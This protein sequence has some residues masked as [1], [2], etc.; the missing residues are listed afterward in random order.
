VEHD[1]GDPGAALIALAKFSELI[2]DESWRQRFA[3]APQQVADDA[4]IDMSA[5]PKALTDMSG[6][7]LTVVADVCKELTAEGLYLSLPGGGTLCYL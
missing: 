7:E 6:D 1:E 5:L 2:Q 4:G 3:E